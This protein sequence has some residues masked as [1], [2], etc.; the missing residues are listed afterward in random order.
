MWAV[1]FHFFAEHNSAGKKVKLYKK[2]DVFI[3]GFVKLLL[4]NNSWLA[5]AYIFC[6]GSK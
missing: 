1:K 2:S 5:D 3:T 4:P 6:C